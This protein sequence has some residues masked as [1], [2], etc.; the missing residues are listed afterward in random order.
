MTPRTDNRPATDDRRDLT[1]GAPRANGQAPPPGAAHV[2]ESAARAAAPPRPGGRRATAVLLLLC[3]AQFVAVLD[4]NA[5]LVALP[6]IGRDLHLTGGGLQWVVTGYVIV[7][8]GCLLAAGRLADAVGRRRV[9][10]TGLALFTLASLAC[11]AAPT[12]AMLVSAR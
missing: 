8:A 9:F 10:M 3:T 2:P 5:L 11:G 4:V 6:L 7:Y 12:A 1:D